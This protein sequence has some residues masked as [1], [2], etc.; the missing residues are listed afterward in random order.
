MKLGSERIAGFEASR[1]AAL[2][3]VLGRLERL[4]LKHEFDGQRELALLRSLQ[5]YV[6]GDGQLGKIIPP[7]VQEVQLAN[8]ILLCDF[9]PEDGQLTLIEQLRDVVTEHIPNEERAWL[10]PL[11]HSYLDLLEITAL[12]RRD[13]SV[14][15]RSL[16]DATTWT[17]PSGDV[18]EYV[19]AG[20]VWL[21]RVIRD[22]AAYESGKGYCCGCG[23]A[24][25]KED[26]QAVHHAVRDRAREMEMQSGVLTLGEWQEFAK[27]FGHVLLWSVA[28]MRFHTLIEAV[29]RVRFITPGGDPYLYAVALY[30]H[31][32]RLLLEDGLRTFPEFKTESH[33]SRPEMHSW[34]QS[35][36][37]STV[38]RLTVTA[39]QLTV[40]CDSRERRDAIKHRLAETFGFVLH[41]RGESE[42]LP[43]RQFTEAEL[44]HDTP[45]AVVSADE[46]QALMGAFLETA[47]LEWAEQK[48]PIL[49]GETPRHAARSPDGRTKVAVLIDEMEQTDLGL[50]RNGIPAFDYNVLRSHVGLEATHRARKETMP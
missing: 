37:S 47:Y 46:D 3:A 16:G 22:P 50:R 15:L 13:D 36:D 11:K 42:N 45:V 25:S 34:A 24:L 17:V 18:A 12:N 4:S 7:S 29:G 48:S 5:P 44:A 14:T 6:Q 20:Q 23:I 43:R 41:F 33:E 31:R 32:E 39:T 49:N 10:D 27:R 26:G 1:P 8:L 38:A 19:M 21:T 40:E 28:E 35:D 30:D 2:D 9:Y